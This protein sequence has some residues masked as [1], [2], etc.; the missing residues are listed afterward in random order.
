MSAK[1]VMNMRG[2]VVR[3]AV[4]LAAASGLA[5][6]FLLPLGLA[7]PRGAEG[8]T[9]RMPPATL[10]TTISVFPAPG[11]PESSPGPVVRSSK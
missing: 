10:Q 8:T 5:A 4:V 1:T 2:T 6:T 3:V 7:G 11:R 9:I